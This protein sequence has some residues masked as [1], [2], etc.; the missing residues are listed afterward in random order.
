[1]T[2]LTAAA[3]AKLPS[4]WPGAVLIL[5]SILGAISALYYS[6]PVLWVGTGSWL[7]SAFIHYTTTRTVR[8]SERDLAALRAELGIDEEVKV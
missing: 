5:F 2:A 1:M 6:D 4:Y 3:P 7:T 8:R